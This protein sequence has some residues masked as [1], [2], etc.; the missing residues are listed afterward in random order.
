MI[1]LR[2]DLSAT[3]LGAMRNKLAGCVLSILLGFRTENAIASVY[4]TTI[5]SPFFT[6]LRRLTLGSTLIV[7]DL[8]SGPLSVTLRLAYS[9][10][11][12]VPLNSTVSTATAAGFLRL[13]GTTWTAV[14]SAAA[15]GSPSFLTK[16][17]SGSK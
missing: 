9:M 2:P 13:S 8:P 17:A 3:R 1:A 14:P 12:T 11:S 5:W 6:S 7:R 15:R 4:R 16:S 10:A